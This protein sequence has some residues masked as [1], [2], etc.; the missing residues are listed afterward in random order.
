L[1]RLGQPGSSNLTIDKANNRK[2]KM[3]KL[4]A[5]FVTIASMFALAT[6]A[7]AVGYCTGTISVV[8]NYSNG[9]V[10]FTSSWRSNLT[11][12]CNLEQVWKGINPQTCWSWFAVAQTAVT[13]SRN[14][15]VYYPSLASSADCATMPTYGSAPAPGYFAI[16]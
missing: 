13:E 6:P 7:H 5:T 2:E 12:V 10:M 8:Y 11:K 16:Q 4:A 1:L 9:D 3:K 14:V 15:I